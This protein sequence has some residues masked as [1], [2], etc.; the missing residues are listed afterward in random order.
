MINP[1]R[2]LEESVRDFFIINPEGRIRAILTY[3]SSSGRNTYEILRLI[4][5]LQ[6]T[7]DYNLYAPANWMP[8]QPVIVPPPYDLNEALQRNK[9]G[10]GLKCTDWYLCYMDYNTI[11]ND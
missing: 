8:G 3:P 4:D 5:T 11:A 6:L 1:D 9:D 2:V 10:L 7:H